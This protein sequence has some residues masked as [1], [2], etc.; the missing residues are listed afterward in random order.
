VVGDEGCG[1]IA[2]PKVDLLMVGESSP[3]AVFTAANGPC[4][5]ANRSVSKFETSSVAAPFDFANVD[6]VLAGALN[7]CGL[8]KPDTTEI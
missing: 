1:G 7:G 2:L 3:N 6:Y 5:S 8:P 4:F